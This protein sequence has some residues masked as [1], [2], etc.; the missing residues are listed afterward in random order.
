MNMNERGYGSTTERVFSTAK[1]NPEGFLLLAA[2]LALLMRGGGTASYD[3]KGSRASD[4]QGSRASRRQPQRS[5]SSDW[6][7]DTDDNEDDEDEGVIGRGSAYAA[8]MASQVSRSAG[9]MASSTSRMAADVVDE[10]EHM[11]GQASST[12][13]GTVRRLVDEQPLTLALFGLAAGVA[14]GSMMPSMAVERRALR[15]IGRRLHEGV[16]E[17]ADRLKKSTRSARKRIEEVAR[18]KGLDKEGLGDAVRDVASAFSDE[19]IGGNEGSQN[20]SPREGQSA[21]REGQS[22]TSGSEAMG[23]DAGKES[24]IGSGLRGPSGLDKYNEK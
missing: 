21:P 3:W 7:V 5:Y 22:G 12:V 8:D 11:L 15:P 9:S 1:R 17:A 13:S 19:M 10:A 24:D 16:D 23:W 2:G 4:W 20:P 6:D 14:V 18:E